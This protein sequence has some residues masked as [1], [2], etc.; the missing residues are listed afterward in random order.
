[1]LLILQ[2]SSVGYSS[3]LVVTLSLIHEG[4]L[5]KSLLKLLTD[6]NLVHVNIKRRPKECHMMKLEAQVGKVWKST[7]HPWSLLLLEA[8]LMPIVHTAGR[9]GRGYANL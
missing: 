4:L 9:L 2:S 1:M 8:L 6:L 5:S 3:A 7:G